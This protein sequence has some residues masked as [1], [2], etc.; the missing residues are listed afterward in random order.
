[1]S[2]EQITVDLAHPIEVDGKTVSSLTLRRPLVRDLIAAERQPGEIGQE[3]ATLAACAGIPFEA[4]GRLDAADY[5]AITLRAE[6]AFASTVAAQRRIIED[7]GLGFMLAPADGQDPS[8]DPG[9]T[10]ATAEPSSSSTASPAGGSPK[11]LD[12]TA[13]ELV[14]WCDAAAALQKQR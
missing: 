8:G 1:M 13:A 12:L 9:S 11:S 3:T 6:L 5:R 4:A 10:G 2:D 7:A 14:A